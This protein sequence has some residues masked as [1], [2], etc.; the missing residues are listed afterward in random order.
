MATRRADDPPDQIASNGI[1]NWIERASAVADVAGKI[2]GGSLSTILLGLVLATY[3]GWIHSPLAAL[4]KALADHDGR[5]AQVIESRA[6]TDKA[7]TQVLSALQGELAKM[8]R[9]QQIRTC[10]E[11]ANLS[12]REMC[13]R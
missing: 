11:I 1:K 12:L 13:L 6:Q 9:I 3:F 2:S 8:N 10:A 7:L 5:V 4:P